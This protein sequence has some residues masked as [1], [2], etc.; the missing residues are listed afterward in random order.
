MAGGFAALVVL[1][2]VVWII[3]AVSKHANKT[4]LELEAYQRAQRKEEDRK[5]AAEEARLAP[6]RAA[7]VPI[8]AEIKSQA[9]LLAAHPYYSYEHRDRLKSTDKAALV[10]YQVWMDDPDFKAGKLTDSD[11]EQKFIEKIVLELQV[12]IGLAE[13]IT[14]AE[15]EAYQSQ[16]AKLFDE[17]QKH[18]MTVA[19][20][21]AKERSDLEFR[22]ARFVEFKELVFAEI[23]IS[24]ERRAQG[25]GF[26]G[27]KEAFEYLDKNQG[28]KGKQPSGTTTTAILFLRQF[29]WAEAVSR[30]KGKEGKPIPELE[31]LESQ[32][33]KYLRDQQASFTAEQMAQICFVVDNATH[34]TIHQLI[35]GAVQKFKAFKW[36]VGC[37]FDDWADEYR[38][39]LGEAR[40]LEKFRSVLSLAA[41]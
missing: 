16:Q 4:R 35:D 38:T 2:I 15:W 36:P 21:Q 33:I 26:S 23:D 41:A 32:A 19:Q 7:F 8:R 28:G 10:R 37:Q 5:K 18:G 34:M 20:W 3:V 9:Y 22:N 11:S 14:Q 13:N 12:Q 6:R 25:M 30:I 31:R 1:A 29:S 24:P 17:A 39:R 40:T 27:L